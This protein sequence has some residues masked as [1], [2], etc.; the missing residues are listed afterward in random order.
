MKYVPHGFCCHSVYYFKNPLPS[1]G[2]YMELKVD[3][4]KTY[5]IALEGG[6]ARG[7]YQVGAWKAL[8][9]AG[10][11]YNAVSGS[12]VGALN[13]ALMAMRDRDAAEKLW[14]D[15]RFSRVMDVDDRTMSDIFRGKILE[16]DIR[17]IHSSFKKIVS[18]GGFNVAPLRSLITEM[19]DYDKLSN[20]GVDFYISTYSVSDRK[21]LDLNARNLDSDELCDMLLA[22]AYFP[23]FKQEKLGG[24]R[25]T[26]GGAFNVFPLSPLI[27]NGYNDI[28]A[29]RIYGLG[30]EKRVKIPKNT[31]V[32]TIAPKKSL[33]NML[34]FDTEACRDNYN[35]G[36]FDAKRMLYGL[37][38]EKYYIDRTMSESDAYHFISRITR[39]YFYESEGKISL[40][41]LHEK[42]IPKI[43]RDVGE[44]GD[45]YDLLIALME[46]VAEKYEI[47]KYE[48]MTD[49]EFIKKVWQIS[50]TKRT[51]IGPAKYLSGGKWYEK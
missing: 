40:R 26:D 38:G 45:Y 16:L 1:K 42:F 12:S 20:S 43:A 10:I 33:G 24:K 30:I 39:R 8:S 7:A 48:I 22:S 21:G 6:G 44:K 14:L 17:H 3:T 51:L 32:H 15:M 49:A 2:V 9:E 13:G 23:A 31:T 47:P 34:D 41:R 5:A 19:V 46:T 35:L 11:K 29:I 28:I 37:Y 25:Y 4:S 50:K 36:Y 18:D 27:E